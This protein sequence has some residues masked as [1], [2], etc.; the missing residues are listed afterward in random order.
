MK[1]KVKVYPG[2]FAPMAEERENA[3]VR[4]ISCPSGTIEVDDCCGSEIP[5]AITSRDDGEDAFGRKYQIRTKWEL[6]PVYSKDGWKGVW[7]TAY[8]AC[9]LLYPGT[10]WSAIEQFE[11]IPVEKQEKIY[12][13]EINL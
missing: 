8:K 4:E 11:I 3:F 10:G 6:S 7:T 1:A 2:G 5:T 13:W 9:G 12:E